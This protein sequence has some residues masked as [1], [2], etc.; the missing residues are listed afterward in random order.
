MPQG[1]PTRSW[2]RLPTTMK[3]TRCVFSDTGTGR[4]RATWREPPATNVLLPPCKCSFT[5]TTSTSRATARQLSPR[6]PARSAA[7]SRLLRVQQKRSNDADASMRASHVCCCNPC[8]LCPQFQRR[9]VRLKETAGSTM[10]SCESTTTVHMAPLG[11]TWGI[12]YP[13]SGRLQRAATSTPPSQ[14]GSTSMGANAHAAR[15]GRTS[16]PGREGR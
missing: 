2:T 1:H 14:R 8:C 13:K 11:A 6:A 4:T 9:A 7:V 12:W 3:V 10:V 15:E 5:L 16:T